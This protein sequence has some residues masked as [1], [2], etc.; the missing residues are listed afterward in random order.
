MPVIFVWHL[1]SLCP[2]TR[3]VCARDVRVENIHMHITGA[4]ITCVCDHW[5]AV[6]IVVEFLHGEVA[7]ISNM[8]FYFHNIKP[9]HVL[10][11]MTFTA[12][13]VW[14]HRKGKLR[15]MRAKGSGGAMVKAVRYW[16]VV[17]IQAA[18]LPV[19]SCWVLTIS[20]P[21]AP[22]CGWPCSMTVIWRNFIAL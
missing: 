2:L 9:I 14:Q 21:A 4:S 19:C 11:E 5:S 10:W 22:F 20:A 13:S 1:I 12:L 16:S 17:R 3:G 7:L 18:A 6:E 8:L 15:C